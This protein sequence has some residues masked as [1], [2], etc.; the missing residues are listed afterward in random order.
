MIEQTLRQPSVA[1]IN[2]AAH[3]NLEF[4]HTESDATITVE[5]AKDIVDARQK[6]RLMALEIGGSVTHV[7]LVATVV[8]ELARN[9]LLY[10][11]QGQI[12]ISKQKSKGELGL[13]IVATDNGPGIANIE[14]A[15]TRGYSTSGGLGLGLSGVKQ[16]VNSFDINSSPSDGVC[17]DV[18]MW[19]GRE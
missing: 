7:T 3:I 16:I 18:S 11:G 6:S 14:Q 15:M 8:S 12:S 10:A 17:V 1:A 19:I 4:R 2:A 9:I 5:S 13:R